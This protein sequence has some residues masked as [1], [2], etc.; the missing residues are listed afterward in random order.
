MEQWKRSV[1]D[2]IA[3]LIRTVT[4]NGEAMIELVRLV[5][6]LAANVNHDQ[7][8]IDRI[9]ERFRVG[10]LEIDRRI[11]DFQLKMKELG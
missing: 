5:S 8:T 1:N 10:L 3:M 4:D 7:Q 11:D 6:A 9:E 2:D